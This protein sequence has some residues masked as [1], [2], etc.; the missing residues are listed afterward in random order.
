MAYGALK[1]AGSWLSAPDYASMR[2]G[3]P[4]MYLDA[5]T[6][7]QAAFD[8]QLSQQTEAL[9]QAE[10]AAK[11][12]EHASAVSGLRG[13]AHLGKF[14]GKGLSAVADIPPQSMGQYEAFGGELAQAVGPGQVA[15]AMLIGQ[16]PRRA[17]TYQPVETSLAAIL[18]L[19]AISKGVKAFRL[20]GKAPEPFAPT[21]NARVPDVQPGEVPITP[22]PTPVAQGVADAAGQPGAATAAAQRAPAMQRMGQV[23]RPVGQALSRTQASGGGAQVGAVLGAAFGAPMVGAAL[24]ALAPN[25]PAVVGAVS[26]ALGRAA[27]RMGAKLRRMGEDYRS[28]D[29]PAVEAVTQNMV[30]E[31][32]RIGRELE[33]YRSQVGETV[34][35]EGIVRT[36]DEYG[37]PAVVARP[38]RVTEAGE[39]AT[40][41]LKQVGDDFEI[42]DAKKA[43]EGAAK[44]GVEAID[45]DRDLMAT[46]EIFEQLRESRK[47]MDAQS[48]AAVGGHTQRMKEA[49]DELRVTTDP[50]KRAT[51]IKEIAETRKTR[52]LADPLVSP[53]YKKAVNEL[54]A[55]E[56][57][58]RKLQERVQRERAAVKPASESA[59]KRL[60]VLQDQRDALYVAAEDAREAHRKMQAAFDAAVEQR[61]K[62]MQDA[63]ANLKDARG[64]QQVTKPIYGEGSP[65]SKRMSEAAKQGAAAE[66]AAK[67]AAWQAFRDSQ[68]GDVKKLM[69]ELIKKEYDQTKKR[70]NAD[71][72]AGKATGAK[73]EYWQLDKPAAFQRISAQ[74]KIM[75]EQ[76]NAAFKSAQEATKTYRAKF[77]ELA[78]EAKKADPEIAEYKQAKA[79]AETASAAYKASKS[80]EGVEAALDPL[81]QSYGQRRLAEMRAK[82][83]SESVQTVAQKMRD[84]KAARLAQ[85][86]ELRTK[87][88]AAQA[89]QAQA[90]EALGNTP[91]DLPEVE[92]N[93][94]G[95]AAARE[96]M[97]ELRGQRNKVLGDDLAS[98]RRI[99]GE[100]V[101]VLPKGMR[102]V[103][104][105]NPMLRRYV[106]KVTEYSNRHN[107]D[108]FAVEEI[109]REFTSIEA[110]DTPGLMRDPYV[111]GAVARQMVAE[112]FGID[113]KNLGKKLPDGR[114]VSD[115]VTKV[116]DRIYE[117]VSSQ[118]R[119]D[120][121]T[122]MLGDI[123]AMRVMREVV[124]GF[125]KE[126]RNLSMGKAAKEFTKVV[127]A[128]IQQESQARSIATELD[129]SFPPMGQ[130][131]RG[132]DVT[133]ANAVAYA[134]AK[135]IMGDAPHVALWAPLQ[136]I[137][138]KLG[139][140]D[141]LMPLVEKY[142]AEMGKEATTGEIRSALKRMAERWYDGKS[143]GGEHPVGEFLKEGARYGAVEARPLD[144]V[145]MLPGVEETLR[146][147]VTIMNAAANANKTLN[148]LELLVR[149][150]SQ[151]GR[152]GLTSG[153]PASYLNNISGNIAYNLAFRGL[154]PLTWGTR[155]VRDVTEFGDWV[156]GKA[157]E[158]TALK[159]D[160]ANEQ[161]VLKAPSFDKVVDPMKSGWDTVTVQK[162]A[163]KIGTAVAGIAD[164]AYQMFGDKAFKLEFFSTTYND[165][166]AAI[167][168]LDVGNYVDIAVGDGRVSRV[169]KTADGYVVNGRQVDRTGAA[170]VA[171]RA[172][173]AAATEAFIDA[174]RTSMMVQTLRRQSIFGMTS[175]FVTWAARS[176][177][178][179]H[180]RGFLGD[181]LFGNPS[182][183]MDTNSS[184]IAE[185]MFGQ[186]SELA[187]KR[188]GL[189]SA[190]R[191]ETQTPEV[192]SDTF[193]Y[194]DGPGAVGVWR[195][196]D[197]RLS[198]KSF[199]A[200]SP[201]G[202]VASM[203]RLGMAAYP[204]IKSFVSSAPEDLFIRK[205]PITGEYE[206]L[207]PDKLDAETKAQ[208]LLWIRINSGAG[209]SG[210]VALAAVNMLG[211]PLANF[212]ADAVGGR[213][214]DAKKFGAIV[215]AMLV[216]PVPLGIY[217]VAATTV[218]PG[219]E[220]RER[221]LDTPDTRD[222]Q[223]TEG[224]L[225]YTL[226][227]LMS[228]GI[229]PNIPEDQLDKVFKIRAQAL[230]TS[231]EKATKRIR[232]KLQAQADEPGAIGE[233][234][235]RRL[236]AYDK[237]DL[238]VDEMVSEL[239]TEFTKARNRMNNARE[240]KIR[241]WVDLKQYSPR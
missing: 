147:R 45:I 23:L 240:D 25:I 131:G 66:Y 63:A 114:K 221:Y 94:A 165:T 229:K 161:G 21:A 70:W 167:D 230:R 103:M 3:D 41:G 84:E 118:L 7:S 149:G 160:L 95:R 67:E 210:K 96:G 40:L 56:S 201:Y 143:I 5:P 116:G 89:G 71:A 168:S 217:D 238:L 233:E 58:F 98:A 223:E 30:S 68:L 53:E 202:P 219:S 11:G 154:D 177:P 82:G 15:Q 224:I 72:L 129:R 104:P 102:S 32:T 19:Q 49:L 241:G 110:M 60:K 109:A 73:A 186:A 6:G 79:E 194:G 10:V 87:R 75:Q 42:V 166:L 146:A 157:D 2:G 134:A 211:G 92:A 128:K 203:F 106:E 227:R 51:L 220:V 14:V 33:G 200:G 65:V 27:S 214:V 228:V 237:A 44:Q 137:R 169:A 218:A 85:L 97:E 78:K 152:F 69:Q 173:T 20:A 226:R 155:M 1:E 141:E 192:V 52:A 189:A 231:V 142:L 138:S 181:I 206:P 148:A 36:G 64:Y 130:V 117:T 124:G 209:V 183:I 46:K 39:A 17:F 182:R 54:N 135:E 26:P 43:T 187:L 239:K 74:I 123:D 178:G 57:K 153:N 101:E 176:R 4:S 179:F 198:T 185:A 236:R 163:D 28:Q 76:R 127:A 108:P 107:P 77:D 38:Q 91:R 222:L 121:Q 22:G 50:A 212:W 24:G 158:A 8:R 136:E 59:A 88:D 171:A 225:K 172:G 83:M 133:P 162:G 180:S 213:D 18:A 197:G 113:P 61:R 145:T 100:D 122:L 125:T 164:E 205:N 150:L 234:A 216:G 126:Q 156:K 199:D 47:E 16:D 196:E 193:S 12:L 119:A 208:R 9:R 151:T 31:S 29:D 184:A 235:R 48:K 188:G 159:W 120:P 55:A 99:S 132:K 37:T 35:R 139:N 175:P 80:K 105:E 115:I 86:D 140:P 190:A 90:R 112:Y 170:R 191:Q 81:R 93:T 204:L 13:I 232:N 62:A 215:S 174:E 195:D 207:D 34:A 144:S 111:R